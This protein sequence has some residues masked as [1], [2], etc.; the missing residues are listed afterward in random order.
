MSVASGLAVYFLSEKGEYRCLWLAGALSMLSALPWTRF[1][2]MP[3]INQLKEKDI[4]ERK[5]KTHNLKHNLIFVRVR[6]FFIEPC[7]KVRSRL[8]FGNFKLTRIPYIYLFWEI[9]FGSFIFFSH[10][11]IILLFWSPNT[12]APHRN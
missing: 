7:S 1:I 6:G 11:Y 5:G 9:I 4:L 8:P 3:D 12:L 2:M 10:Y